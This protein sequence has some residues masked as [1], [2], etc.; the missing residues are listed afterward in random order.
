MMH[1]KGPWAVFMDGPTPYGHAEITSIVADMPVTIGFIGS[2]KNARLAA[3][4]VNALEGIDIAAIEGGVVRE[5]IEV[6]RQSQTL[7]RPYAK[8][9]P[10]NATSEAFHRITRALAKIGETK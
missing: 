9:M 3:A 2:E 10:D 8:T 1:T 4:C 5:L 6:L 7:L